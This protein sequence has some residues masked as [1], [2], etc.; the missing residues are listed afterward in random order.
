MAFFSS[1]LAF[2][3]LLQIRAVRKKAAGVLSSVPFS[4]VLS[5]SSDNTE[6]SV[7]NFGEF[8]IIIIIIKLIIPV[9]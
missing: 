6:N 7:Y 4:P 5:Q 2:R 9:S 8:I 1:S 3:A